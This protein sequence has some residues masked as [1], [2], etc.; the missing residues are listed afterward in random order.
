[1]LSFPF[2]VFLISLSVSH[3][4]SC[5]AEP[6]ASNDQSKKKSLT[7]EERAAR[8]LEKTQWTSRGRGQVAV[9]PGDVPRGHSYLGGHCPPRTNTPRQKQGV[10]DRSRNR[11][12]TKKMVIIP[13]RFL[14]PGANRTLIGRGADQQGS[15][16]ADSRGGRVFPTVKCP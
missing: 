11:V 4:A 15:E 5:F 13:M 3:F 14:L 12:T 7:D 1:M 8:L 9:V 16:P 10:S 2:L 6:M